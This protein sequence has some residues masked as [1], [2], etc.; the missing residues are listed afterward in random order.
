MSGNSRLCILLQDNN[1]GD[2]SSTKTIILLLS[3]VLGASNTG[4]DSVVVT[5]KRI[6]KGFCKR[7]LLL[8]ASSNKGICQVALH[9]LTTHL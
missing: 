6:S 2:C 9:K 4:F 3:V 8:F 5:D 1:D 7:F